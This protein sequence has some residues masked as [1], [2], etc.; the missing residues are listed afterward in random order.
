MHVAAMNN[1]WYKVFREIFDAIVSSKLLDNVNKL[2]IG[3]IGPIDEFNKLGKELQNEKI[4]VLYFG[5]VFTQYEFPTLEV[6]EQTCKNSNEPVLYCHTKGVSNPE[7]QGKK[8]WRRAMI[9]SLILEWSSC[10]DL[11]KI[12]DLVGY[13]LHRPKH[14]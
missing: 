4:E 3:F 5:N 9:K 1:S 7:H 6:L 14:L 13:N 12:N 11:L 2:T 10:I 8:Y